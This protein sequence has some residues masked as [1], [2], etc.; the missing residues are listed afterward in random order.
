MRGFTLI[1]LLIVI[2]IMATLVGVFVPRFLTYSKYQDLQDAVADLQTNIRSAQNNATSGFKC[3]GNT[4]AD[5][6]YLYFSG[7][8]TYRVETICAGPTPEAGTPTPTPPVSTVYKFPAGVSIDLIELDSCTGID[9]KDS[10]LKVVF[11]SI[12]GAVKFEVSGVNT[13]CGSSS[14]AKTLTVKLKSSSDPDNPK[15]VI[16]E[17]G[18]S[19]YVKPE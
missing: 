12:S 18:G 2:A 5:N 10:G 6:W 3:T 9:L 4:A 7:S 17:K 11:S 13:E 8:D 14:Y 15:S 19:V 16:I 1:E